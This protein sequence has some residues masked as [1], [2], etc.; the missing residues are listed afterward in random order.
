MRSKTSFSMPKTEQGG[1]ALVAC[2]ARVACPKKGKNMAKKE[3]PSIQDEQNRVESGGTTRA[4]A[5]LFPAFLR[6]FHGN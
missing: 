6:V 4:Y 3:K 1:S 2:G 5:P